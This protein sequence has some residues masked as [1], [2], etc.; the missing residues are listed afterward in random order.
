MHPLPPHTHI[1]GKCYPRSLHEA[2]SEAAQ[3]GQADEEGTR[4]PQLEV[5]VVH[6]HHKRPTLLRDTREPHPQGMDDM[7]AGNFTS[8]F[9]KGK[10]LREF[11]IHNLMAIYIVPANSAR[12]ACKFHHY[13]CKQTHAH[14]CTQG[15]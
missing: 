11:R 4:R 7:N 9:I 10:S 6:P 13:E 3:A 1:T 8:T 2:V 15:Y 14:T 5:E 12:I